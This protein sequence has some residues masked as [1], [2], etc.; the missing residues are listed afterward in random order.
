[1]KGL[2]AL[3]IVV[4]GAVAAFAV[5]TLGWRDSS[6]SRSDSASVSV[7]GHQVITV[8]QVPLLT[9]PRQLPAARQVTREG[10]R[11]SS[12]LAPTAVGTKWSS[13]R[14]KFRKDEVQVYDLAR[15]HEPMVATFVVPAGNETSA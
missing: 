5:Y 3:G 14:T 6:E 7:A 2:A 12:E 9:S 10:S 1:L 4:V 13:G 15:H 11:T 8:H